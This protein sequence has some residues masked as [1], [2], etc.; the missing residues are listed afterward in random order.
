MFYVQLH[1]SE[2]CAVCEIMWK[3]TVEPDRP[4]MTIWRTRFACWIPKATDTRTH[5]HT[6]ARTHKHRTS[7]TYC[8]SAMMVTRTR[9]NVRYIASLFLFGISA[10]SM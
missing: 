3:N 1:S 9:L 6:H 10:S 5:I 2:N 7:N 8:F 4:Q